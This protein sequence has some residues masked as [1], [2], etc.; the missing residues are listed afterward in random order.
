MGD[1]HPNPG[2]N[3]KRTAR[4]QRRQ[5]G[6]KQ[7]KIIQSEKNKNEIMNY[8]GEW[9]IATWNVQRMPVDR[10]HGTRFEIGILDLEDEAY[11]I[12]LLQ[13]TTA[14]RDGKIETT[15]WIIYNH[16]ESKIS[17]MIRKKYRHAIKE[18]ERFRGGMTITMNSGN[19][20]WKVTNTYLPPRNPQNRTERIQRWS[21]LVQAD[22]RATNENTPHIIGGDMNAD[23]RGEHHAADEMRDFINNSSMTRIWSQGRTSYT[24]AHVMTGHVYEIDH[25]F[26]NKFIYYRRCTIRRSFRMDTDHNIKQMYFT[27]LNARKQY[28]EDEEEEEKYDIRKLTHDQEARDKYKEETRTIQA[29]SWEE[30]TQK[31]KNTVKNV[32]GIKKKATDA[33]WVIGHKEELQ[34][35]KIERTQRWSAIQQAREEGEDVTEQIRYHR[36]RARQM[37]E[38]LIEWEN[39]H[40]IKMAEEVEESLWKDPNKGWSMLKMLGTRT[41]K[42]WINPRDENTTEEEMRQHYR[43]L[44]TDDGTI[45]DVDEHNNIEDD[46]NEGAEENTPGIER[47]PD[48]EETREALRKM[49]NNKAPG[50][51]GTIAEY[52]KNAS[53]E[54]VEQL[55]KCIIKRWNG[56]EREADTSVIVSIPKKKSGQLTPGDYRGIVLSQFLTRIVSKIIQQRIIPKCE[57]Y[58]RTDQQGFRPGRG[59]SEAHTIVARILEETQQIHHDHATEDIEET[60]MVSMDIKKAFPT[61]PRSILYQACK[62]ARFT[63]EEISIIRMETENHTYRIKWDNKTTTSSFRATRGMREG[64]STSPNLYNLVHKKILDIIEEKRTRSINDEENEYIGIKFRERSI[65]ETFMEQE[66]DRKGIIQNQP[67]QN[68]YKVGSVAYADDTVLIGKARELHTNLEPLKED[69]LTKAGSNAHSGKEQK[70]ILERHAHPTNMQKAK[71]YRRREAEQQENEGITPPPPPLEYEIGIKETMEVLGRKINANSTTSTDSQSRLQKARNKW[72]IVQKWINKQ[73]KERRDCLYPKTKA[74]IARA[75]VVPTL[76]Y[77][78]E[79]QYYN[80]SETKKWDSLWYNII[81]RC[82]GRTK[83]QVK[84]NR[85]TFEMLLEETGMKPLIHHRIERLF[86]YI[87]HIIRRGSDDLVYK[88]TFG[89]MVTE[90]KENDN[91]YKYISNAG[92]SPW[93][94][95]VIRVMQSAGIQTEAEAKQIAEDREQW[96]E[97]S[98]EA[99]QNYLPKAKDPAPPYDHPEEELMATIL[100]RCPICNKQ[101][102]Q[103]R[104]HAKTVHAVT[105]PEEVNRLITTCMRCNMTLPTEKRR[106]SHEIHCIN[107]DC[108][109]CGR[110][111]RNKKSYYQHQIACRRE[112][113]QSPPPWARK[114]S[115]CTRH[116]LMRTER[117][118]HEHTC[119]YRP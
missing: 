46:E 74:A 7:Q 86:M 96:R 68:T 90:V 21:E 44:M 50:I 70:M 13:D 32:C 85:I 88:M 24:W 55:H 91:T 65:D 107:E 79:C 1:V 8:Q 115:Y 106:I 89:K 61:V 4:R 10:R 25:F 62:D 47:E 114:C 95:E 73:N 111:F 12:V 92:N 78:T 30:L 99:V 45:F 19:K 2:P 48:L 34:I 101:S 116:F 53:P 42:K 26:V 37:K 5:E 97:K 15:K 113:G 102:T 17:T 59:C 66:Y 117:R 40:W 67:F 76:L 41:N 57:N 82:T 81:V 75:T 110:N 103:V 43:Q 49:K 3:N 27:P 36:Q 38:Q 52:Y 51:D 108:E 29:E 69:M 31:V 39:D 118:K 9:K 72:F 22:A 63:K 56:H 109:G 20:N 80:L 94:K 54:L 100:N 98:K 71:K 105:H 16:I 23:D 28:Q 77:G 60:L 58:L 14:Y 83:T 84:E 112:R 18:V 104:R 119:I 6:K 93:Q 87:G 11:D 33:P 35:W 64:A